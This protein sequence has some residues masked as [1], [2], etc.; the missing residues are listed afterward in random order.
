MITKKHPI[1]LWGAFFCTAIKY[2]QTL[3]TLPMLFFST[4]YF[5]TLSIRSMKILSLFLA[6]DNEE[7]NFYFAFTFYIVLRDG[8][9]CNIYSLSTQQAVL[10]KSA[11]RKQRQ[12]N[13]AL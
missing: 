5:F 13:D 12:T 6:P 3:K 8:Q 10:Y 4:D 2:W 1:I 9:Y 7:N 11:L